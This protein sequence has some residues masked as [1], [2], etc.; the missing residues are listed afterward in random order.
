MSKTLRAIVLIIIAAAVF[1]VYAAGT[2][3]RTVV[4]FQVSFT[5]GA[6]VR[7][8]TFVVPAMNDKVQVEIKIDSGTS[9]WYAEISS[10]GEK[11]WGHSSTQKGQTTYMSGWMELFS[12]AYNFTFGTVGFGSLQGRD[13]SHRQGRILV[14]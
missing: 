8:E 7:R 13:S 6:D 10:E 11:V 2:Y 14:K 1:S 3:P 12:G 4:S 9:L 5:I